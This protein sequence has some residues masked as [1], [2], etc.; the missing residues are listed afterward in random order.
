[1]PSL[2]AGWKL[3]QK[4]RA[5]GKVDIIGKDVA[6]KDYVART[7]DT[8]GVTDRDLQILA[9][10]NR[11]TSTAADFVKFYQSERENYNKAQADAMLPEYM[12]A[13]EKVVSAGLHLSE[14]RIGYSRNYDRAFD[15]WME[16]ENNGH[17]N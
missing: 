7:T 4:K 12:E 14:S 1:M 11:N 16:R 17:Q 2:P 10:G 8:D 15:A 3:K 5:D 13:A 9:V 6:G